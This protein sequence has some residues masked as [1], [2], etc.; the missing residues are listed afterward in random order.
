MGKLYQDRMCALGAN[1]TRVQLSGEQTHF[2]T[3]QASEALY[4]AWIKERLTGKPLENGC[5]H[6]QKE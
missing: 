5:G 1:I 4:I 2:T 3:P 6:Q